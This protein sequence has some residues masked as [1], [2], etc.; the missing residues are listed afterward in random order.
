[1]VE[2]FFAG[3]GFEEVRVDGTS[4]FFRLDLSA[5]SPQIELFSHRIQTEGF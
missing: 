3:R 2:D 5:G 4:H 1:M